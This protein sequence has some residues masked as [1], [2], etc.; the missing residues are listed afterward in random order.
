MKILLFFMIFSTNSIFSNEWQKIKSDDLGHTKKIICL[1][2]NFCYLLSSERIYKTTDKGKTWEFLI[3]NPKFTSYLSSPNVNNLFTSFSTGESDGDFLYSSNSGLTFSHH[4]IDSVTSFKD[5]IMFDSLNGIIEG[6]FLTVPLYYILLTNDNWKT[7]ETFNPMSTD[8]LLEKKLMYIYGDM[9]KYSEEE[10]LMILQ[11]LDTSNRPK[12]PVIESYIMKLNIFSKKFD[13]IKLNFEFR[14]SSDFCIVTDS[15]YFLAGNTNVIS[16]GTGHDA[17]FKTIDAG[18]TWRKVLDLY[19]SSSKIT[20]QSAFGLQKIAF[21][22]DSVGIA[23]GQFGKIVYT[24]DGGESWIYEKDLPPYLGGSESNPPTMIIEYAGDT[25]IIGAFNGTIHVMTE[26]TY[27][28]K[29]EDTLTI[30]GR[31]T[32]DGVGLEGIAISLN[33][34]RIT[35][36]DENGYY[37][38]RKLPTGNHKVNAINKYY[39]DGNPTYYNRPFSFSS[40]YDLDLTS[41]T[42]EIDFEATDN[43]N[44]YS[45]SGSVTLDGNGLENILMQYGSNTVTTNEDGFFLFE[46]IEQWR[47]NLTPLTPGYIYDPEFYDITLNQNFTSMDFVASP[48]TYVKSNPNFEFKNNIIYSKEIVG[49]TYRLI[50]LQGRVIKSSNLSPTIDF[51]YLDNGTYILQITKNNIEVFSEKFQVVR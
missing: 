23:V 33:T 3:K 15:L 27:A 28:P 18:K 26:D 24:Y 32:L 41:D 39:D 20:N 45:L 17:I 46:N 5:I 37:K 43:R 10:I 7:Y 47:H 8:D 49:H 25:P 40:E 1:D 35:M 30:S 29:P 36:T 13:L 11:L 31:V 34:Y 16:G 51:N 9:E 6:A 38:F 22:N 14:L 4:I 44:F 48:I 12:T 42:T 2:T 50:D 21:K 19:S